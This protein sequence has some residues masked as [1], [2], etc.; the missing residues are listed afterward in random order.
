M[1]HFSIEMCPTLQ[2]G[3]LRHHDSSLPFPQHTHWWVI[4]LWVSSKR[5]EIYFFTAMPVIHLSVSPSMAVARHTFSG[6]AS[7]AMR[8]YFLLVSKTLH[9]TFLRPCFPYNLESLPSTRLPISPKLY[10]TSSIC[11]FVAHRLLVSFSPMNTAA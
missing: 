11:A 2:T 8:H 5:F 10:H 7:S 9:S 4:L 3:N 1:E 6:L